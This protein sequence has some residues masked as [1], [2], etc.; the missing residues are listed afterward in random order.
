MITLAA[1]DALAGIAESATTVTVTIF[2]LEVT[3]AGVETYKCLY[4]GQLAAAAATLYTVPASTTAFVRSVHVVNTSASATK[5]FQLFRGGTAAA[6]AIT[7]SK[8]LP[9]GGMAAYGSDGWDVLP[10]SGDSI[11]PTVLI[12]PGAVSPA[13]VAEGSIVWDTDDDRLTVGDGA[14][15]KTALMG[16]SSYR[17]AGIPF[18]AAQ[19][20]SSDANTLDDY[21]EAPWTPTGNGITFASASGSYTKVGRV[22]HA[23]FACQWPTT[24]D[25]SAA[26]VLG[27]PYAAGTQH[28]GSISLCQETTVRQLRLQAA[29]TTVESLDS[30]GTAITNA[31]MSSDWLAGSITYFV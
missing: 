22:V 3:T 5:T 8:T 9:A 14:S 24:A 23:M 2:G 6:N 25:G 13:Q 28:G 18:P 7:D 21:E 12:L 30:V 27:L 15:R 16:D 19:V 10:R 17:F 29:T 20:A 1:A 11:S 26:Q 4:Q 31:T